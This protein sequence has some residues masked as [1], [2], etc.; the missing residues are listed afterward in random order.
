ML[1]L[2]PWQNVQLKQLQGGD[3]CF[4]SWFE[5]VESIAAGML[6]KAAEEIPSMVAGA[7]CIL[8]DWDGELRLE[9]E[10]AAI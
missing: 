6:R 2:E 10:A 4:C 7:G 5:K 3:V 9:Y 8:I 1:F